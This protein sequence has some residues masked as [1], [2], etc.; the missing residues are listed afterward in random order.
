MQQASVEKFSDLIGAIYDCVIAPEQ[1]TRV[2][3]EIRT[4]FGF[5]TAILSACSLT[6][7]TIGVNAAA[8][9]A[10]VQT[11]A[12]YSIEYA[13]DIVELWGGVERI[14]QYPLG[15]PIIRS[16]AVPEEM[17][18]GNRYHREWAKPKGLSDA[19]GVALVRDKTMIG[20]ATLAQHQSAG[21][22]EDAQVHGLRVLAPHIRRA[23]TISNLFD[24]K[25][26]EA[27][28]FSATVEALTAGVVLVDEDSKIVHSN[29]V[30]T[31]MLAAGDP[32]LTRH[33]RIAVQSTATTTS[34]QS[35]I[36][37]A[38]KDEAALGQ[39]GI[40]IPILRPS[41]DPLVIHVMPL[42]R[43]PVRARLAQRAAAAVFVASASGPPQMS[44]VALNQL[45]DL[46]PAE[47]RIFEL[48]CE[49]HTRDAISG[50]LGVSVATVKSHLL[51]VFEKTG[52]RRQVDLV[53]LAKSLTFPV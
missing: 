7:R 39:K 41:G 28:T 13:A 43:G 53:R 44:H 1:W 3:N 42:R 32:I 45:Y 10:P 5:A 24:M 29:A 9:T 48:I 34:L 11:L 36:A 23:V 38:A 31:A 52:C 17:I 25:T 2:L 47:I 26:V 14:R 30:A 22:I 12:Q 20:N 4:E 16:Q 18:L 46:T 49:G 8:G 50:L 19:V 15:E 6:N 33:G 51:H 35:A 21:P 40:G 37:Q 27:A